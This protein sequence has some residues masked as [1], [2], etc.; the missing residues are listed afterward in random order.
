MENAS[1]ALLMAAGV[2]IGLLILSLGVFLFADFGATSKEVYNELEAHQLTE[3]NAQYTV[4]SGRKDITIYEIVSVANLAK[5]NNE[6]YK[7]YMDFAN[8]YKVI[9]RLNFAEIQN[10]TIAEKQEMISNNNSVYQHGEPNQVGTIINLF[11]CDS[12]QYHSNGKVKEI[13]FSKTT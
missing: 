10:K 5:Q 12:I 1:K 13:T 7:D 3:Y 8:K 4:Y 9:V 11:K 2:L 6:D